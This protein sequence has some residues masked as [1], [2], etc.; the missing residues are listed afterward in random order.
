[1][2]NSKVGDTLDL[3]TAGVLTTSNPVLSSMFQKKQPLMQRQEVSLKSVTKRDRFHI[4]HHFFLLVWNIYH[5]FRVQGSNTDLSCWENC[6]CLCITKPIYLNGGR[7]INIYRQINSYIYRSQDSAQI[8]SCCPFQGRVK[9][10]QVW[11]PK[12]CVGHLCMN[13]LQVPTVPF[14]ICPVRSLHCICS[15]FWFELF[16]LNR[17]FF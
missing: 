15:K 12:I 7:H 3:T 1:M 5:K 10:E 8:A 4:L 11:Y 17:P 14:G 9:W 2:Q 13:L 16:L 6:F